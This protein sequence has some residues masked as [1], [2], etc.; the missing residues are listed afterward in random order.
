MLGVTCGVRISELLA[1]RVRDV[2]EHGKITLHVRVSRGRMKGKIESRTVR[3]SPDATLALKAWLDVIEQRHGS[4]DPDMPV[5]HSR[6]RGAQGSARAISRVQAWRILQE[7]L[8]ADGLQGKL[9]TRCLRK[10]FANGVYERY[11]HD[12]AKTQK[13]LGHKNINSTLAYLSFRDEEVEAG[14]LEAAAA[15][16]T[17]A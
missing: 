14:I 9:G 2:L 3:L 16:L 7:A 4:L 6:T 11:H 12:L 10:T 5:F 15:L 13:A 8:A 17:A 1:L